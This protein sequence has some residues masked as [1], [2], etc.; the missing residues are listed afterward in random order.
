MIQ[1]GTQWCSAQSRSP[2]V[3]RA[4]GTWKSYKKKVWRYGLNPPFHTCMLRNKCSLSNKLTP[5]K[6][7]SAASRGKRRHQRRQPAR[8]GSRF[9]S[10]P[11]VH[12]EHPHISISSWSRTSSL[13]PER[14]AHH[15]A[16]SWSRHQNRNPSAPQP[17]QPPPPPLR[18]RFCTD[19]HLSP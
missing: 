15:S 3:G 6:R 4:K 2:A 7:P 11:W 10:F 18:P 8:P 17:P 12:T 14:V 19:S 13:C 5:G 9:P 1:A 16:S